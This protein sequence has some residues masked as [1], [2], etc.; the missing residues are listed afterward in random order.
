MSRDVESDEIERG[1]DTI[2]I[3]RLMVRWRGIGQR[4]KRWE[5]DSIYIEEIAQ[6]VTMIPERE[7]EREVCIQKDGEKKHIE[8]TKQSE[9]ER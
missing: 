5:R 2:L 6:S 3:D 9:T 7:E 1:R 8:V 4:R